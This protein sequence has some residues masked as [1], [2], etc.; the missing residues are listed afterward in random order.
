MAA[1][2][3]DGFERESVRDLAR[4][5]QRRPRLRS[6]SLLSFERPDRAVPLLGRTRAG[7]LS[8]GERELARTLKTP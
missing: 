6:R 1:R 4:L 7:V 2:L 5:D 8:L 3:V